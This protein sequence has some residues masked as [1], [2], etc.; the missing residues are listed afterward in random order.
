MMRTSRAHDTGY[1]FSSRSM[2]NHRS[3][4]MRFCTNR[5]VTFATDPICRLA[6]VGHS[7][8]QLQMPSERE[9]QHIAAHGADMKSN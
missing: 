5:H 7:S 6:H 8:K 9:R 1:T 3:E 4:K 2:G